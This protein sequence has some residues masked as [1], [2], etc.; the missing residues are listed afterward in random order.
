[1]SVDR[2]AGRRRI[3]AA[4]VASACAGAAAIALA[5]APGAH[6]TATG[7]GVLPDL[8]YGLATNFGTGCGYT[9]QAFVTDPVASVSFY[10]NGIP[11]ATVAPTGG[12]ALLKWVPATP[13]WH[14]ISVAQVPDQV[15]TA[16]TA[17]PVGTGMHVG[18]GCAVFGG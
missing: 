2:N 7:I 18:H 3:R 17:V 11:L 10:D 4:V 1:M 5:A 6:A 9:I 8:G 16:A 15:T 12:V 14:T 13:G